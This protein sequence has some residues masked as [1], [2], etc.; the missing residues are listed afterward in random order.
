M[1]IEIH[2]IDSIETLAK[3]PFAPRTSLIS[4][5]DSDALP[6]KLEHKPEHILRLLFDDITLDEARER[7]ELPDIVKFSDRKVIVLLADYGFHV[8]NNNQAERIAEFVHKYAD[9]TDVLICQCH[10]GQSRSA[11]CAAAIAEH[12]Y[13]NGAEFFADNRYYPNKLVFQK[14]LETLKNYEGR[15]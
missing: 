7:F 11:G 15:I 6:P 3:S 5:G 10:F 8:F 2:S 1:K 14:V 9:V 12:F 4:I 13:Q